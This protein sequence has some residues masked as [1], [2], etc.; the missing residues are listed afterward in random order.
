MAKG[1]FKLVPATSVRSSH[2]ALI[3]T[4]TRPLLK[5]CTTSEGKLQSGASEVS[6]QRPPHH[7]QLHQADSVKQKACN[8]AKRTVRRDDCLFA[9][10]V[11]AGLFQSGTSTQ[12]V[13]DSYQDLVASP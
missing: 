9:H 1:C 10:S 8:A 11:E 12:Q 2:Q 6:L 13:I 5:I 4:Q 3:C 7:W